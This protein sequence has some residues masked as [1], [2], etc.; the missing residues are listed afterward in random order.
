MIKYYVLYDGNDL[1]KERQIITNCVINPIKE[2]V[3]KHGYS[4]YFEEMFLNMHDDTKELE[5]K[6]TWINDVCNDET[7]DCKSNFILVIGDQCGINRNSNA[8]KFKM[9]NFVDCIDKIKKQ[10]NLTILISQTVNKHESIQQKHETNSDYKSVFYF[11]MTENVI[12]Y[13]REPKTF[14]YEVNIVE[15]TF[16]EK[17]YN[18]LMDS[19]DEIIKEDINLDLDV[20]DSNDL[21]IYNS[22]KGL[23]EKEIKKHNSIWAHYEELALE[24]V[25]AFE[26]YLFENPKS[27]K[28]YMDRAKYANLHMTDMNTWLR[29]NKKEL[30]EPMLNNIGK[31]LCKNIDNINVQRFI[32]NSVLFQS[33]AIDYAYSK[34]QNELA[35][36]IVYLAYDR[37]FEI[38]TFYF[39]KKH[40]EK[41]F[42]EEI[43]KVKKICFKRILDK[44]NHYGYTSI[45]GKEFMIEISRL[46]K[47]KIK[48]IENAP[49]SDPRKN[50]EHIIPDWAK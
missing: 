46:A 5:L 20:F 7:N 13:K 49:D 19:L 42:Y 45:Y 8:N 12:D 36:K 21:Q 31:F 48:E 9:L 44:I 14:Y 32:F 50:D 35:E 6:Q 23:K 28:R 38:E 33:I 3:E 4:F 39:L 29:K 26:K 17:L 2:K 34:G 15:R 37:Y 16:A 40:N 47:Q 30:C 24:N 10:A 11:G 27:L 18:K 43:N 1:E 22:T 41:L 25:V